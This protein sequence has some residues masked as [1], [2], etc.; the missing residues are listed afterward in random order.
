MGK[1]LPFKNR[2]L[3]YSIL[4]LLFV[5]KVPIT[6]PIIKRYLKGW[7][8]QS[9]RC[10]LRE[11]KL[12]GYIKASGTPMQ[13]KY[14]ITNEGIKRLKSFEYYI[15]KKFLHKLLDDYLLMLYTTGGSDIWMN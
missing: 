7:S 12:Q 15:N 3:K 2:V 11:L 10:T 6:F 9:L 14:S 5:A 13:Y 8:S 4:R 1:L